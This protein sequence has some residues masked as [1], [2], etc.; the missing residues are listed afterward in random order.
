[1]I[2][3]GDVRLSGA[4]DPFAGNAGKRQGLKQGIIDQ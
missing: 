3:A 2:A 1:M 4:A